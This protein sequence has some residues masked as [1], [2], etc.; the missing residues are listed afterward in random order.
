LWRPGNKTLGQPCEIET[1]LNEGCFYVVRE[2]YS[3]YTYRAQRN[4]QRKW[5]K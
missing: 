4:I 1:S 3:I 2:E 5:L